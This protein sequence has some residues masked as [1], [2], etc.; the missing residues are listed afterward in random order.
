MVGGLRCVAAVPRRVSRVESSVAVKALIRALGA[1]A[2]GV[3]ALMALCTLAVILV[4]SL[5]HL[6]P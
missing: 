1:L 2:C 4:E 6:I 5:E 3:L